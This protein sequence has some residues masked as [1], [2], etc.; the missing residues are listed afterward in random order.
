[1]I[2]VGVIVMLRMDVNKTGVDV[3]IRRKR[4]WSES[5]KDVCVVFVWLV[6]VS[7]LFRMSTL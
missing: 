1:M 7:T 6:H 2:V 3:E 4:E 5:P